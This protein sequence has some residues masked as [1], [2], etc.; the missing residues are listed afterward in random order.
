MPHLSR[1]VK[2][3]APMLH[4]SA[5]VGLLLLLLLSISRISR[6]LWRVVMRGRAACPLVRA[7]PHIHPRNPSRAPCIAPFIHPTNPCFRRLLSCLD[8][9]APAVKPCWTQD[10]GRK[11]RLGQT[12]LA[13]KNQD[14]ERSSSRA[15]HIPL[16]HDVTRCY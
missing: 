2:H 14:R 4:I 10:A 7:L 12:S 13:R 1:K 6:P 11:T 15:A 16:I 3:V 8:D 9:Q 5:A